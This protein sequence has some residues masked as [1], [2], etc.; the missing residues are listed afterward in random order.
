MANEDEFEKFAQEVKD[1]AYNLRAGICPIWQCSG[2]IEHL[3]DR[4]NWQEPDLL[5]R[6][7][8]AKWKLT[9]RPK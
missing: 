1:L 9:K 8:G 6:S 7:C 3:E 2:V 4:I 5:C